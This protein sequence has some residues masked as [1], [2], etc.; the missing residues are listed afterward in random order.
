[1]GFLAAWL[2]RV[3]TSVALVVQ[4]ATMTWLPGLAARLVFASVLLVYFYKSGLT[5]L[6]DGVLGI[7][8]P[9]DGAYAQILPQIYEASG[10]DVSQLPFLPYGAIVLAGTWAEFILPTMIVLGLFTR[11][12]S[13]GMIIFIAVMTYV[14]IT[15]HHVE[16]ATIGAFFDGN[17]SSL[18]ADQRLLWIFPLLFLVLQGPGKLSLDTLL[19]GRMRRRELYY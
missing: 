19:G 8:M 13:L 17:P 18:M 15:G 10:Y 16:A 6:G 7:F 5:K 12:S 1:M 3:H 2:Y 9:S 11:I 4:R 14:D